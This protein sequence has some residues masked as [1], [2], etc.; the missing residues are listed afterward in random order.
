ME[1]VIVDS[2]YGNYVVYRATI[3][4]AKKIF[5]CHI[6]SIDAK[7]MEIYTKKTKV[8]NKENIVLVINKILSQEEGSM[9]SKTISVTKENK[10][11]VVMYCF[12]NKININKDRVDEYALF[13]SFKITD[14]SFFA[15][16]AN[17]DLEAEILDQY[18]IDQSRKYGVI[19]DDK[20]KEGAKEMDKIR[21]IL[22]FSQELAHR[23]VKYELS[24]LK[25]E[26]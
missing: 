14:F 20:W 12:N 10:Q 3:E 1:Q 4:N 22:E 25:E 9:A 5:N 19:Q 26:V 17:Y 16:N 24:E 23:D 11:E 2:S 6:D 21:Y 18:V 13:P 8:L 15:N 7:A